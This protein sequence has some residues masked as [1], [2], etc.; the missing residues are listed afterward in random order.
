[1]ESPL[2]EI[3]DP[4]LKVIETLR[5]DPHD[6]LVRLDM[7]LARAART[8]TRLRFPFDA[9]AVR[10]QLDAAVGDAPKRCRFTVDKAGAV[11]TTLA[12][13]PPDPA[14]WT[15]ALSPYR[16]TSNDPWLAL[17]TTRRTRHDLARA[18]MAAGIDEVV[19]LNEFDALCE[20]TI[21]SIFLQSDGVLLT[22]AL[23]CGLL[24]GVLRQ[25]LLETG[26]AREA[27]LTLQDMLDAP[28]I[29]MGN[30]LRGLIEA[31]FV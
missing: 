14:L 5:F 6:G 31:N 24:P 18:E 9:D 30:S 26:Q 19:L 12:E 20:G 15:V 16:L 22:P 1:M 7:H 10:R 21:S 29:Y 23:A 11:E 2:H 28:S 25:Q 27:H 3:V 17:K 13:L 4:D 8:C